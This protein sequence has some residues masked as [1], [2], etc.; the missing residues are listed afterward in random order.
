MSLPSGRPLPQ[1]AD[2]EVMAATATTATEAERTLVRSSA[3]SLY[4]PRRL[5]IGGLPDVPHGAA[6][7]GTPQGDE[8]V[9]IDVESTPYIDPNLGIWA[10]WVSEAARR[11]LCDDDEHPYGEAPGTMVVSE[12]ELVQIG[13]F[14]DGC[15]LV[16]EPG[17]A[18]LTS[19]VEAGR[20]A[21]LAAGQVPQPA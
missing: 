16:D 3:P 9:A 8:T 6:I 2:M 21:H 1:S 4:V 13:H 12:H 7:V 20:V 10:V 14:E 11:H 18:R 15:I 17:R 5:R 19:W